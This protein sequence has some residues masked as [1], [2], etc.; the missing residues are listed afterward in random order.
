[1]TMLGNVGAAD[2]KE[3]FFDRPDN[4]DTA[5]MPIS[6]GTRVSLKYNGKQ[7]S[8]QVTAIERL[9]TSFVGCVR[10]YTPDDS[11]QDEVSPGDHIRFRLGDVCRVD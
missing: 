9:G 2:I 8:A 4:T 10:R 5:L 11:S 7:L 3:P 6:A 1:M